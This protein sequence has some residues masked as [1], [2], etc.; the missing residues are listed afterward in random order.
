M[1]FTASLIAILVSA[2]SNIQ[3]DPSPFLQQDLDR[4]TG[5]TYDVYASIRPYL[6]TLCTNYWGIDADDTCLGHIRSFSG[7]HRI[8]PEV[9]VGHVLDISSYTSAFGE[10]NEYVYG[11]ATRFGLNYWDALAIH[12]D[13]AR[14]FGNRCPG[15]ENY[16]NVAN[17]EYNYLE[18]SYVF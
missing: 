16:Y 11:S 17:L 2:V 9:L 13:V 12:G 14:V 10:L 1:K 4:S 8:T 5:F 15:Y 18:G 7:L 6:T 3:A